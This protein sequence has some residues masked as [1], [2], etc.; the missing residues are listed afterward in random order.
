MTFD[1]SH[2]LPWALVCKAVSVHEADCLSLNLLVVRTWSGCAFV[3]APLIQ[4][5]WLAMAWVVLYSGLVECVRSV[6]GC[7][8]P[9][10]RRNL[11][12]SRGH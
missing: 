3:N 11:V 6:A 8:L 9:V 7:W 4:E 2:L 1:P 5:M 10:A 12:H